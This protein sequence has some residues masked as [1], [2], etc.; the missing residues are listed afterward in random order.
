MF[1]RRT[2]QNYSKGGEGLL[3]NNKRRSNSALS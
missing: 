2:I 1:V 3:L